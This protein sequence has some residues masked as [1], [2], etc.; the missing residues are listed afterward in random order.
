MMMTEQSNSK[1]WHQYFVEIYASFALVNSN[2]A[3]FFAKRRWTQ[4]EIPILRGSQL[5]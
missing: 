5:T 1:T 3:K 4:E 2:M